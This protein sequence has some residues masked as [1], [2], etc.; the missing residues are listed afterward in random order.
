MTPFTLILRHNW[1]YLWFLKTFVLLHFFTRPPPIHPYSS[2][3]KWRMDGSPRKA[4]SVCHFVDNYYEARVVSGV[5]SCNNGR[6]RYSKHAVRVPP[7]ICRSHTSYLLQWSLH[8]SNDTCYCTAS[9]CLRVSEAGRRK[10]TNVG[11]VFTRHV[12]QKMRSSSRTSATPL[13][14]GLH[15]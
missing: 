4:M 8:G 9:L 11:E 13:Q 3:S 7:R 10:K 2:P 1:Q 6:P 15:W 14:N 5:V 12:L